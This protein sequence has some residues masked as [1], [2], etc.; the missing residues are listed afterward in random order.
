[1]TIHAWL[2]EARKRAAAFIL[3][4]ACGVALPLS[5][6]AAESLVR[7]DIDPLNWFAI[8][9]TYVA[10]VGLVSRSSTLLVF[11]LL[12]AGML[13]FVYG[14]DMQGAFDYIQSHPAGPPRIRVSALFAQIVI[15]GASVLYIGERIG[16]HL[17]DDR[18]FLEL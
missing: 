10:G 11:M 16:R 9:V 12:A 14:V 3:S 2:R 18:P 15:T 8:G 13:T 7:R 6:L 4:L 5:P 1:M 17:F